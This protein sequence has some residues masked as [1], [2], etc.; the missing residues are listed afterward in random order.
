MNVEN[1]CCWQ[2][3]AFNI[4]NAEVTNK[5]PSHKTNFENFQSSTLSTSSHKMF[6]Q[7]DR[8]KKKSQIWHI[9]LDSFLGKS[10]SSNHFVYGIYHFG[11]IW[12]DINT[13]MQ[14]SL[15]NKTD[16]LVIS[17]LNSDFEIRIVGW[18]DVFIAPAVKFWITNI[19]SVVEYF[20]L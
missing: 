4:S 3:Q 6:S 16:H 13:L 12:H 7:P 20:C 5:I 14:I 2:G 10:A 15:V 17:W 9:K 1:V 8:K 11:E 19:Q 18:M